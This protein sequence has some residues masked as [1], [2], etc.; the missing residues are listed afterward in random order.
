MIHRLK[1]L[2]KKAFTPITI[3]FVPH[4]KTRPL[5]IKVPFIG[6]LVSIVLWFFGTVY[7]FTATVNT[8]E[9]YRMKDKVDYYSQEFTEL[10]TTI[11]A[12]RGAEKEFRRLFS[13]ESKEDVLEHVDIS[14]SGSIDMETLKKEIR[15]TIEN[16]GE[17]RDYLHIQRDIYMATPKG[18][19]VSGGRI[20][21]HYGKRKHPMNGAEEFHTGLDIS[22]SSGT[23]VKATADGIVS[24]S[25]WAGGNGYLV[26]LE[27][28]HDFSTFYAHNKKNL[29]KVGQKVK[30]GDV[31]SYVGTTGSSTGPH[32]HYEIWK[33]RRH[34]NPKQ[35]I[36]GKS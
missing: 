29:V 7:I 6:I 33:K 35:Y 5:N 26:V 21:S 25:G 19:P 1:R 16:V 34:V 32:V 27:H 14:D 2:F 15:H 20:S 22:V 24:F 13:L 36:G 28:G 3:M 9:Y 31:I 8:I 4:S 30:R 23:P 11:S 17:V 12:I 18:L 10:S